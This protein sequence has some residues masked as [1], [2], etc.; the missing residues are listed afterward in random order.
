MIVIAPLSCFKLLLRSV[1]NSGDNLHATAENR[2]KRGRTKK[3]KYGKSSISRY[4]CKPAET[5]RITSRAKAMAWSHAI[6]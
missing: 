5:I 6:I 1:L 3:S 2:T 4:S